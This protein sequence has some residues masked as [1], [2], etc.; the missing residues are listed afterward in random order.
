MAVD[1]HAVCLGDWICNLTV[2]G[3]FSLT[4]NL[5][6]HLRKR[7]RE[8]DRRGKMRMQTERK[9][10][11][12]RGNRQTDGGGDDSRAGAETVMVERQTKCERWRG[13][14]KWIPRGE[15]EDGEWLQWRRAS[16]WNCREERKT[17]I[18][19]A[20]NWQESELMKINGFLKKTEVTFA[21]ESLQCGLLCL[22]VRSKYSSAIGRAA[23]GSGKPWT[24][25]TPSFPQWQIRVSFD[26]TSSLSHLPP[27]LSHILISHSGS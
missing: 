19:K 18:K 15:G 17:H 26:S 20:K 25:V 2:M 10:V 14:S 3:W 7:D 21:T 12:S 9:E 22:Q 1:V 11:M 8:M 24:P 5:H 4:T 13:D 16:Y 6:R 27:A 23:G